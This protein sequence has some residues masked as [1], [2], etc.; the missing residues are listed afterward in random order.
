MHRVESQSLCRDIAEM[1]ENG[2]NSDINIDEEK[3][4]IV[5][6]RYYH[7]YE[8]NELESLLMN[9]QGCEIIHSCYDKSNWCVEFVK[10]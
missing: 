6:K 8:E 2:V 3:S 4:M 10:K 5:L 7:L 9:L 1:E